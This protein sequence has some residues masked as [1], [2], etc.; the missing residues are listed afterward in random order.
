[1]TAVLIGVMLAG[2]FAMVRCVQRVTMRNAGMMGGRFVI[3]TF[4]VRRR[5]A[6]MF[7][8]RFVMMSSMAVM[9]SAFV[10]HG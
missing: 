1:V 5:F 10:R 2:F 6:V 8:C 7:R 4:V 3:A 9:F